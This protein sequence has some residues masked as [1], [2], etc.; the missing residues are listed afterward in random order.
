MTCAPEA[1]RKHG[2]SGCRTARAPCRHLP[3]DP[4]NRRNPRIFCLIRGLAYSRNVFTVLGAQP[5]ALRLMRRQHL[6]FHLNHQCD[7]DDISRGHTAAVVI[8]VVDGVRVEASA[9]DEVLQ[10]GDLA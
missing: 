2:R 5:G 6:L 1:G 10:S 4:R 3:D 8:G 7:V 9:G